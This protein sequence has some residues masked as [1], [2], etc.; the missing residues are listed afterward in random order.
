MKSIAAGPLSI[1]GE[2]INIGE[3]ITCKGPP[4]WPRDQVH[5]R[6][7]K[8]P[9]TSPEHWDFQSLAFYHEPSSHTVDWMFFIGVSLPS[10]NS[11]RMLWSGVCHGDFTTLLSDVSCQMP[12]LLIAR[13]ASCDVS[14]PLQSFL[15]LRGDVA[16]EM[17]DV[18]AADWRKRFLHDLPCVKWEIYSSLGGVDNWG[19]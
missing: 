5:L 2:F 3:V 10:R 17:S 9:R 7:S 15:D 4:Y 1:Q 12:G 8:H 18:H 6:Q 19:P 16:V 11:L 13:I 14:P